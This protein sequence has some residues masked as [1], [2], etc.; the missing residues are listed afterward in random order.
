MNL[1]FVSQQAIDA[2]VTRTE[3]EYT[4]RIDTPPGKI[5][6]YLGFDFKAGDFICADRR[7]SERCAMHI[8]LACG[9]YITTLRIE[10][11]V[12]GCVPSPV[13]CYL[14]Y[15]WL[16]YDNANVCDAHLLSVAEDFVRGQTPE[17][18]L[19]MFKLNSI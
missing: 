12:D 5:M 18:L 1:R 17:S 4:N 15:A 13:V 9:E 2:A 11:T 10:R 6:Q 14:P 19:F 8:V 3:Y 16:A 7:V